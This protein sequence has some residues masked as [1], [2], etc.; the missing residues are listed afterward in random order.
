[1]SHIF[2]HVKADITF[3][4]DAIINNQRD[5]KGNLIPFRIGNSWC[6]IID[7]LNGTLV[8]WMKGTTAHINFKIRD[9]GEYYLIDIKSNERFKYKDSYVPNDYLCHGRNGY[10]DYIILDIDETG[11]ILHYKVPKF[12]ESEWKLEN[13]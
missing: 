11:K 5:Y 2:L 13:I 7:V 4:E 10:G 12:T 3:W 1:M 8:N 6:P 9:N